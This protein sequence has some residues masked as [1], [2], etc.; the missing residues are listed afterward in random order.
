L[1]EVQGCYNPTKGCEILHFSTISSARQLLSLE[2]WTCQNDAKL[3]K[4]SFAQVSI[5]W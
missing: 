5:K 3:L 2:R 4:K 1:H